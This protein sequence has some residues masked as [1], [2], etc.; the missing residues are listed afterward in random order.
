MIRFIMPFTKQLLDIKKFSSDYE[1]IC[2]RFGIGFK[3]IFTLEE[4]GRYLSISRE[5]VRQRESRAIKVIIE[6][7]TEKATDLLVP[8]SVIE[9]FHRLKSDLPAMSE[10][11]VE[12]EVI[13][14]F[15][16]RYKQTLNKGE[17]RIIHFLMELMEFHEFSEN[18]VIRQK[19]IFFRSWAT[20]DD[21][22][23]RTFVLAQK[24]L[25]EAFLS[26]AA[27]QDMFDI[28]SSVNKGRK[29]KIPQKIVYLTISTYKE[30]EA[31]DQKYQIRFE[32][33][34]SLADKAY[35][36]LSE[37][38]KPLSVQ[39]VQLE[40][41]HRLAISQFGRQVGARSIGQ[42]LST[43]KRFI[44]LGGGGLW[45]LEEWEEWTSATIITLMKEFLNQN[46][47]G[48]SRDE[49]FEYVRRKRPD[50][51]RKTVSAYLGQRDKFTR[52]SRN[53]YVPE[54]WKWEG[55][56]TGAV[57]RRKK[58][59]PLRD[60]VRSTVISILEKKPNKKMEMK[61]LRDQV[62]K[63][64][65]CN[66]ATFY[67]Y[68]GEMDNILKEKQGRDIYCQLIDFQV[69]SKPRNRLVGEWLP[70]IQK[71][72]S[73]T[74]EFKRAAKW[75][76][77]DKKPDGNMVQGIIQ[78]I[79]G[80]MNAE[81]GYLFIGVDDKTKEIIGIEDDY[82]VANKQK[83]NRDGYEL[84]LR[85]A[86]NQKIGSDLASF[87]EIDFQKINS[88]DVCCITISSAPKVVFYDGNDLYLRAG[89][90]AIKLT[91]AEAID[92]TKRRNEEL[93]GK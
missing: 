9:E 80:F 75:N 67:R 14:F 35:R 1:I 70:L 84:F 33:L 82:Q 45:A 22:D 26:V 27:P 93:K 60:L 90:Q 10:V 72:E 37:K 11:I 47:S 40:I 61:K 71:G 54:E 74:V 43:D 48:A 78:G 69:T 34:R 89:N 62:V 57:N 20:N 17:S 73:S 25:Y 31:V 15:Q 13:N 18:P 65:K 55:V 77:F 52:I 23:T 79:A 59:S 51:L 91:A 76:Y 86:I 36:I 56:K 32:N 46:K 28:M 44:P 41:N 83:P 19:N 42:Q 6:S 63:E 53:V 29:I 85:D 66:R 21:F 30:L 12:P 16:V 88:N 50:V 8:I 3:R 24:A 64:I 38:G 4:I 49:I 39:D 81:G 92:F 2:R 7:L 58:N 68:L 5:R 87:Y